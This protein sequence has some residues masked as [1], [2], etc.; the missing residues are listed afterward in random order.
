VNIEVQIINKYDME[1]RC[2]FYWS[3]LYSGQLNKGDKYKELK[4]TISINIKNCSI[5]DVNKFHT[6]FHIIED[7]SGLKLID[8]LEIHFIEMSKFVRREINMNAKLEEWLL[9]L[10]DPNNK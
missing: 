5:F 2:L 3:K 6:A 7:E 8:D 9:F 10:A 1:K 4:K